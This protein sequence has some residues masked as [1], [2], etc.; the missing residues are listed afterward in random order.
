MPWPYLLHHV[1][2]YE[3]CLWIRYIQ[4]IQ[5]KLQYLLVHRSHG[6][7]AVVPHN[8]VPDRLER[9][10]RKQQFATVALFPS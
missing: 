2:P 3:Q 1:A 6:A 8:Q 7:V 9:P 10:L 5:P 4:K